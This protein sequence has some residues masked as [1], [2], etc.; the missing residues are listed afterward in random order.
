MLVVALSVASTLAAGL[1]AEPAALRRALVNRAT[2]TALAGNLV[3][4]PAV[5]WLVVPAIA[6]GPASIGLLLVAT[7]P[8]GGIGP[9]LA[10][11][12]R[13]DASLAGALFLVLS[14]AGTL[15]ALVVMLVLG[16]A[17]AGIG[18]VAA[19]TLAPLA[20][21]FALRRHARVLLPVASRLGTL[22]LIAT[23][24][25]FAG[26]HGG[27]VSVE[28]LGG[29]ALLAATSA[30]VGWIAAHG[31]G[32]AATIAI[33]QISLVRNVAL[34]LVVVTGLGGAPEALTSVLTYALVMLVGGV[35]F[36]LHGRM[37]VA[38]GRRCRRRARRS[39]S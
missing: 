21:G 20:L 17:P 14:L 19:S 10:L 33:V 18:L 29:A 27:S 23:V 36:A 6:S 7:A 13:G 2:W 25:Y 38:G 9:L 8:G 12:A 4:V 5:A 32:R 31:T 15:V 28:A 24:S 39:T 35:A 26:R 37:S 16:I 30:L 1:A 22:L 34:S 11:L 3:I